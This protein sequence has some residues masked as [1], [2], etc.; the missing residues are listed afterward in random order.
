MPVSFDQVTKLAR[1]IE[2]D[3]RTSRTNL[4][5]S[6]GGALGEERMTGIVENVLELSQELRK[7]ARDQPRQRRRD[8]RQPPRVLARR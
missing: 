3:L 4:K 1:D 8:D 5:K 7:T 6:L 2:L